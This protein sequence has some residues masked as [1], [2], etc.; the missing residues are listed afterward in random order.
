MYWPLPSAST[1]WRWDR[2]DGGAGGGW[3]DA[4]RLDANAD[5][6]APE[7]HPWTI[8]AGGEELSYDVADGVLELAPDTSGVITLADGSQIQFDNVERIEW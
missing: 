8:E 1:Y 6:N 5:P 3:T 2:F 7:S 4:V